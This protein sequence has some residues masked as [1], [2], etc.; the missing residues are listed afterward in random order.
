MELIVGGLIATQIVGSYL[1][2]RTHRSLLNAVVANT[3]HEYTKLQQTPKRK[4][5]KPDPLQ[6][7]AGIPFG[8]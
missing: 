6:D 3:P 2:Y 4:V 5:R 1:T 8:L 7:D